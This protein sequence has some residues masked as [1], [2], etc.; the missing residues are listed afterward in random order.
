MDNPPNE[1][2]DEI[3]EFLLEKKEKPEKRKLNKK[4]F[5]LKKRA[6]ET[7]L[8]KKDG[9]SLIDADFN[10]NK[11]FSKGINLMADEKLEDA[12][13]VF[14]MILRINP[15]DVD[16]LLK[17]GYSRFHLEDYTESMRAY[18][19]VLDIDV[20]NADAW[21]LKS[22]VYYERK[23]YGKALDCIDKAI[24]SDPTFGMAWYN[25]ACYLSM[26]NQ[27]T[28]SLDALVRSIE[29]DVKNAKRAVKDKDFMNVRLEEGFKRIVE[30]VVIES[31][32]Q[33]Y[34][35]IGAIVWTTFLDKE[36]VIKCL[37]R[38][39]KRGLVVKH[40]KRQVWST[41]DTYDLIPEMANK[42]GTIKRGMLGIPS[43]SLPKPI[44][45]LKNLAEAIQLIKSSIEGEELEK[46]IEYCNLFIDPDKCGQEM[47]DDFLEEHREIR[48][49]KIRLKDKGIDFL[50]DNQKKM[51][52]MFENM[53]ISVTKRLRSD[54]ARN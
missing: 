46:T 30:V 17:L 49:F 47:I 4:S 39:M 12:S 31:L 36:D 34:H 26:L 24:D 22:L 40:E 18:D 10:R 16:A 48:L 33:G 25:R 3:P 28:E 11:L 29:I 43:K 27:I 45:N 41:I 6:G 8:V 53:E 13:H 20:T 2:S 54:L 21:N 44:K 5:S 9:G 50:R 51:L 14:E 32:R 52:L 35:T 37:T 38:L 19:K 1:Q 42:I 15:N 7:D 23:V